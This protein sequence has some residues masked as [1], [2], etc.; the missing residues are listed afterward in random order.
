ACG[1]AS[2]IFVID[3][4]SDDGEA[5][6]SGLEIDNGALPATVEA[7]TARGRHIYFRMPAATI[8]NSAGRIA[9]GI[10]VRGAG[11]YVLA[12]PSIHPSGR[13]YVWSVDSTDAFADAPQWLIDRV[14]GRRPD[15]PEG[16]RTDWHS[17]ARSTL[18]EGSRNDTISR[19]AGYLLC[20]YV[21]AGFALELLQAWNMA[22]C[23]P[24][25]EPAEVLKTV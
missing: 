7:I 12:P 25:L 4:D 8:S 9:A 22:H 6:P 20:R 13:T 18:G 5:A 24:P 15:R 1:T 11:G 16:Q 10:D 21:D 14:T 23:N 3:I 17:V 2:G 19:M